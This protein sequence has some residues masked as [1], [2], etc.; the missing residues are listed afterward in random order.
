M[1]SLKCGI[2]KIILYTP[3]THRIREQIGGCQRGGVAGLG[4]MSEGGQKVQTSYYR[5][6]K[7][8]GCNDS[9]VSIVNNTTLH[10]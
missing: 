9:M 10:I 5:I 7:F 4:E 2:L 3:Q 8:W 6:N 1:I